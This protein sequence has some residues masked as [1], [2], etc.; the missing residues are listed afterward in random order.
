MHDDW[1]ASFFYGGSFLGSGAYTTPVSGSSQ[2]SSRAVGLRYASGYLLGASVTTNRWDHA[3][4][5]LEYSFS[6]QPVTFTNLSDSVPSLSLGHSIHRFAYNVLYYPWDRSKRLRPYAFGGPGVS[7]F[8]IKGSSKD[9]AA[10][11]GISLS[12]P[13]KFTMNWGGGVKYLV[14]NHAA[15]VLQFSD[16]ICGVP[17]YGL[18][19]SGK[20]GTAG[21]TA[22][23]RPDGL[24]NNWMIS[25][26][27]NYQWEMK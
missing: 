15:A 3:G 7:L 13:W 2:G 4:A 12:D 18:P 11:Q 24:M 25:I 20:V 14:K 10:A 19:S 17:G 16:S 21:Y 9:A 6:N 5:S 23:F 27:F 1:E 8:Y 22:G 26:G